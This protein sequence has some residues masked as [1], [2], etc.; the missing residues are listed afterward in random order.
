MEVVPADHAAPE[1]GIPAV[2]DG[3]AVLDVQADVVDVA[4]L[5]QVVVAQH[6]DGLRVGV[7]EFASRHPVA[8]ALHPHARTVGLLDA[9]EI[10]QDAVFQVVVPAHDRFPVAAVELDAARAGVVDPAGGQATAGAS[11]V[12][13]GRDMADVVEDAVLDADGGRRRHGQGIPTGAGEVQAFQDQGITGADADQGLGEQADLEPAGAARQQSPDPPPDAVDGIFAPD[14][15]FFGHVQDPPFL[16]GFPFLAAEAVVGRVGHGNRPV[17]P[18]FP[19]GDHLV[20]PAV[21]EA[22]G[23]E[24]GGRIAPTEGTVA[25]EPDGS[26]VRGLGGGCDFGRR[27]SLAEEGQ[28]RAGSD[29]GDGVAAVE[30]DGDAGA[31]DGIQG[32]PAVVRPLRQAHRDAVGEERRPGRQALPGVSDAAGAFYV[33]GGDVDAFHAPGESPGAPDQAAGDAFPAVEL[34]PPA[35]RADHE[36]GAAFD[37]ERLVQPVDA[38]FQED[39]ITGLR[40]GDGFPQGDDVPDSDDAGL[41]EGPDGAE[42]QCGGQDPT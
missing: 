7:V 14:G 17:G 42:K 38:L 34:R 29:R 15:H 2:I 36:A 22:A 13:D 5:D 9:V 41:G 28:V 4:A 24:S 6:E 31:D 39:R 18:D 40:P 33:Q 11:A 32:D 10:V 3:T 21:P 27:R 35:L 19:D 8:E 37:H 30:A 23:Q 16:E 1:G 12:D 25:P 20:S 26:E